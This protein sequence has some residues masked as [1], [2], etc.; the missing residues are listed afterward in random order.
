[1]TPTKITTKTDLEKKNSSKNKLH[2]QSI[3]HRNRRSMN[4]QLKNKFIKRV[5]VNI[6]SMKFV[7]NKKNEFSAQTPIIIFC[8]KNYINFSMPLNV[9]VVKSI[10]WLFSSIILTNHK[11]FE[12]IIFYFIKIWNKTRS[13]VT[14]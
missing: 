10:T 11:Q 8:N 1:M 13:F 3:I 12:I 9:D 6:L 4:F 7:F 14:I 5:S 2:N